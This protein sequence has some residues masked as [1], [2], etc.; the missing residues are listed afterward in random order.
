M[1]EII[2]SCVRSGNNYS[3]LVEYVVGFRQGEVISP[4]LFSLFVEDLELFLQNGVTSGLSFD[5]TLFILLLFA[6]DM[7][8]LGKYVDEINTSLELLCTYCN[9]WS[10]G[11]NAQ[12]TKVMIFEKEVVYSTVTSLH[13]MATG[14]KL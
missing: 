11:V 2:K 7:V 5:D 1:Y 9:T 12:K 4:I 14:W 6:D 3:Q 13:I 10:L 8:I